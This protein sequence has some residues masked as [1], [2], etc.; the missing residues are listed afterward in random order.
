MPRR[1]DG[2]LGAATLRA[3]IGSFETAV[4]AK[5]SPC[6]S[7]L[8]S[9]RLVLPQL[10]FAQRIVAV[11]ARHQ[12]SSVLHTVQADN[13]RFA[14]DLDFGLVETVENFLDRKPGRARRQIIEN[15]F[16]DFVARAGPRRNQ[17]R[18]PTGSG[19]W[20]RLPASRANDR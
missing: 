3:M 17:D 20:R 5:L 1:H 18:R 13:Q 6:V 11:G 16:F 2:G 12:F 8:A 14:F 19:L 9:R 7:G 15:E 10:H 4:A